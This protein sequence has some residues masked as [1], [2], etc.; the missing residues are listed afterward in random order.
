MGEHPGAN[1]PVPGAIAQAAGGFTSKV[2]ANIGSDA[3][4][5][6]LAR[7]GYVKANVGAASLYRV[8]YPTNVWAAL[9]QGIAAQ[10]RP[11]AKG[12][13]EPLDGCPPSF[14][15]AAGCGVDCVAADPPGPRA[16][17]R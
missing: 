6:D 7:D 16:A 17:H 13:D 15:C 2:W 9:G 5:Y 1:S 14:S 4:P 11:V 10:V 12:E 8:N 3:Q